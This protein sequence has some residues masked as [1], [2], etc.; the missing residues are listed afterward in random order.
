[1]RL[2]HRTDQAGPG[3][4]AR[5]GTSPRCRGSRTTGTSPCSAAEQHLPCAQMFELHSAPA[6]QP[7]PIGFL[8]QLPP[9]QV[10]G[11][12]QSA[13][14]EQFVRQAPFGAAYVRRARFAAGPRA[15]PGAVARP[16]R[17]QRRAR[18]AAGLADDAGAETR[19]RAG[20]VTHAGPAADGGRLGRATLARVRPGGRRQTGPLGARRHAGEAGVRARGV[21]ADPLGAELGRAL[22]RRRR[23]ARRSAWAGGRRRPACRS[24]RRRCRPSWGCR[25]ARPWGLRRAPALAAAAAAAQARA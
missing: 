9:M 6:P 14:V 19:A 7:A 8:P 3:C 13:S 10:L 22:G 18:A 16:G 11:A 4:R 12:R 5:F 25:P 21:A 1:M 23:T 20:A 15:G 24:S 17:G 2:D